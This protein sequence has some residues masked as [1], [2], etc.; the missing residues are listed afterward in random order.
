MIFAIKF[1]KYMIHNMQWRAERLLS[2]GCSNQNLLTGYQISENYR[3]LASTSGTY[4]GL[5]LSIINYRRA[6]F[7]RQT[8][9]RN[10]SFSAKMGGGG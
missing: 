4:D 7:Y 2:K 5:G 1:S 8:I 6:S 10:A 9:E 3:Q